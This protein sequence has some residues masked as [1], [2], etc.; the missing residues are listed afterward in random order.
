MPK[1]DEEELIYFA[2]SNLIKDCY[3][4]LETV[5][6]LPSGRI[7]EDEVNFVLYIL[8]RALQVEEKYY[9]KF[10]QEPITI[11]RPN[12]DELEAQK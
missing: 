5:E 3:E 6:K 4:F 11:S 1:D 12:W 9:K 8:H 7:S 10:N 2:I